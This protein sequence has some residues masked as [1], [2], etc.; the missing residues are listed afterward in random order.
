M[1]T[2]LARSMGVTAPTGEAAGFAYRHI[3]LFCDALLIPLT[4]HPLQTTRPVECLYL[5]RMLNVHID[6]VRQDIACLTKRAIS[7]SWRLYSEVSPT[8]S[9]WW[10]RDMTLRLNFPTLPEDKIPRFLLYMYARYAPDSQV[11]KTCQLL[12][13]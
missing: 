1:K 10:I 13:I 8:D 4:A 12:V 11:I 5:Y 2:R 7:C 6:P 3:F 9:H